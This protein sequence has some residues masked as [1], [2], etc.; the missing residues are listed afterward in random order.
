MIYLRSIIHQISTENIM[1]NEAKVEKW[2]RDHHQHLSWNRTPGDTPAKRVDAEFINRSEGYEIRD[3]IVSY[4]N[5]CNLSFSDENF[6]KTYPKIVSYK[7][8]EKVKRDEML[9]HLKE[10]NANCKK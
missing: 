10:N 9:K 7:K 5:G 8:G 6:S 2:L 4:Y 1:S 3:L